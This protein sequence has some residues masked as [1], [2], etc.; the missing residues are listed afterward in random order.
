MGVRSLRSSISLSVT[1]HVLFLLAWAVLIGEQAAKTVPPKV[2]WIEVDPLSPEAKRRLEEQQKHRVVESEQG[3]KTD[4]AEPDAFLGKQTQTVDRQTVNKHPSV[5]SGVGRTHTQNQAQEQAR[6]QPKER[7]EK[8]DRSK[9]AKNTRNNDLSRFGLPVLPS[10]TKPAEPKP[11]QNS[12]PYADNRVGD[13]AAPKDYI[14]GLKEG[15]STAL[16]TKEYMFY[17]YFQRIRE[18]LDRAWTGILREQI[19]KIFRSGRQL[20]S[21]RDLTTKVLVTMNRGGEIV[22][23]QVLEESGTMDLDDAAVRAFN[24]AGPFPN[25]PQGMMDGGGSVQIRW[26][27]V[28]RT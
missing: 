18:R 7:T 17:G 9:V 11:Q 10:L 15:E 20:A 4:K 5:Q 2:T 8:S 13:G 26:D 6:S 22:R 23:V 28:L 19:T 25:P 3:K 27:F 14:K 16:N 24:K 12:G 21:D 1:V